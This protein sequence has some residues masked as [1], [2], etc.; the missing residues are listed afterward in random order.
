M[1]DEVHERIVEMIGEFSEE[2]LDGEYKELGIKLADRLA[3]TEGISFKDDTAEN[4]ACAIIFAVG[5]LNFLFERISD[6]YVT[7]DGLCHHFSASRTRITNKAKDIR[8]RLELKLGNEEFSTEFVLSL[9]I[10]EDDVDLKRIRIFNEVKSQI[11]DRPKDEESLDNTQILDLISKIRH[12][13]NP[14]ENLDELLMIL[15]S[16]YFIRPF[17]SYQGLFVDAGNGKYQIPAFTSV[18]ECRYMM[19]DFEDVRLKL[20]PF[21]N[22]LS[23]VDRRNFEGVII[24]PNCEGFIITPEM[25]RRV[26]PNPE[27]FDY[28]EIFFLR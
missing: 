22:A 10:P 12:G 15:R 20:W 9:G 28:W 14:D 19:N 17:S 6:P 1:C 27:H 8:R 3:Q 4:W 7:R 24:N 25:I 2:Y 16:A 18:E 13:E 21:L 11:S 23:P 5:Q 26:Y